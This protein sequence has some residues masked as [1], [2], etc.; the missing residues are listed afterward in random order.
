LSASTLLSIHA[1]IR[2]PM[3]MSILAEVSPLATFIIHAHACWR[4]SL[5]GIISDSLRWE[6]PFSPFPR[7]TVLSSAFLCPFLCPFLCRFF[8][9]PSTSAITGTP[10]LYIAAKF[11]TSISQYLDTFHWTVLMHLSAKRRVARH[12][13]AGQKSCLAATFLPLRGKLAR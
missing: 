6:F 4:T 9:K 8:S 12:F 3:P 5:P 7:L 1:T 2:L 13:P 10:T 11:Q